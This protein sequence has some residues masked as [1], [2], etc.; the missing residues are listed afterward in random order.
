MRTRWAR[1]PSSGSLCVSVVATGSPPLWAALG[2]PQWRS[3]RRSQARCVATFSGE[4][5][6]RRAD[7]LYVSLA[8]QLTEIAQTGAPAGHDQGDP[9][10]VWAVRLIS[11]RSPSA[12]VRGTGHRGFR[13]ADQRHERENPGRSRLGKHQRPHDGFLSAASHSGPSAALTAR[14]HPSPGRYQPVIPTFVVGWHRERLRVQLA[15][16]AIVGAS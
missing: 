1:F 13:A 11:R 15:F 12:R 8:D 14:P 2:F 10:S 3:Q 5:S 9:D 7:R 6:G 4:I 16:G